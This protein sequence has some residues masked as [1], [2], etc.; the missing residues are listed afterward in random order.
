MT[1]PAR[2]RLSRAKGFDLQTASIAL[3]GLPAV[4]VARPSKWGNP[5]T[6]A[7]ARD[8]GF[9]GTDEA[10]RAMVVDS[11]RIWTGPLYRNVW[12]G[13]ESEARRD[14][15]W[16]NLDQLAGKNLACWCP[17]DGPCHADILL[18]MAKPKLCEEVRP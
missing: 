15:I 11:F 9:T 8:V 10:L 1:R 4:N 17:L 18:K 2:L 6:L 16:D 5:F 12:M 13:P 14:A 7:N 3:N